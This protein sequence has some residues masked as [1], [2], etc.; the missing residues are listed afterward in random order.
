MV[1]Q[2]LSFFQRAPRFSPTPM[3][4]GQQELAEFYR[5]ESALI[6]AGI[7]VGTDRGLSDEGE[8]W[9]VFYRSDDGEV[10]IHFARIDGEY[11]IAGPANAEVARGYDFTS[12]VRNMVARHPMIR[13][14][15]RNDNIAIHPA[16]LLIAVVGTAFF[17]TGEARADTGGGPVSRPVLMTTTA[18]APPG[19]SAGSAKT[20]ASF[21]IPANEAV[22][23]MAAALL[24]SDYSADPAYRST[25]VQTALR[26]AAAELDFG[27][28]TMPDVVLSGATA[29]ASATSPTPSDV[30]AA[31]NVS[32]VLSLVALLLSMPANDKDL[33]LPVSTTVEPTVRT[34][35]IHTLFSVEST[36]ADNGHWAIDVRLSDIRG[37]PNLEAVQLVRASAGE[38]NFQKIAVIEVSE[39][40]TVLADI[41]SRGSQFIV[42]PKPPEVVPAPTP[43]EDVTPTP[44]TPE[45]V[46][47]PVVDVGTVQPPLPVPPVEVVAPV[48]VAPVVVAPVFVAPVVV[49]PV[50][51]PPVLVAPVVV[52]PPSVVAPPVITVPPAEV[53]LSP[54]LAKPASYASP[55][56]VKQFINYFTAH[57]DHIGMMVS[58]ASVVMYDMRVFDNPGAIDHITAMTFNFAD[59]SSIG[60]VGDQSSFLHFSSLI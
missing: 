7:S 9:F 52:A 10:V 26:A 28:R 23:V 41:L 57:T 39:L 19:L 3:D 48:V 2:V 54:A 40:P 58:A 29:R 27:G 30:S 25:T 56:M 11:I 33:A 34:T 17:K 5:V 50:V 38:T 24:A 8:P 37:L 6:R 15:D 51:V 53:V 60:L 14:T 59:G 20:S 21:Q 45:P 55:D 36:A 1:A 13:K 49:A 18:V 47:P 16:A 12:L 35:A 4:W 42:A 31:Q 44:T 32:T 43:V 22:M 46:Q